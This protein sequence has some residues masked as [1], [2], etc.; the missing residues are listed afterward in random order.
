M[1]TTIFLS[2]L[3]FLSLHVYGQ[4]ENNLSQPGLQIYKLKTVN[5]TVTVNLP[6]K[7]Y[8][9]E[10]ISGT[11]LAEP[12]A[13][14]NVKKNKSNRLA[15]LA[16]TLSIFGNRF[17]PDNQKLNFSLPEDPFD[18]GPLIKLENEEGMIGS[19][20]FIVQEGERPV[21]VS[22]DPVFPAFLRSGEYQNIPGKFD[23]VLSNTR[24]MLNDLEIPVASESPG[25]IVTLVP[26]NISGNQKLTLTEGSKTYSAPI[27]VVNLNMTAEAST[28]QKGEKST[29]HIVVNGLNGIETPV[30]VNVDN[31]TPMS[32][33]MKGGNQQEWVIHPSEIDNTGTVS[34]D[35]EIV[36]VA[37]GGFT[38]SAR[39]SVPPVL[40]N[41]DGQTTDQLF[42]E[43]DKQ[44][45]DNK[46]EDD[47]LCGKIWKSDWKDTGKD[48]M[49]LDENS[50]TSSTYRDRC[51]NCSKNVNYN[52]VKTPLCKFS[53]FERQ[54]LVC[55]GKK[56]HSGSCHGSVT[57]EQKKEKDPGAA[58]K[59]Y[60]ETR[61]CQK[62]GRTETR[63]VPG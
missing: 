35:V 23:G 41:A 37:S 15:L 54:V 21:P 8:P 57:T 14:G 1:R 4:V 29:V 58:P 24:L 6:D 51:N 30:T 33:G 45:G 22:G 18:F 52:S 60:K 25:E 36:A 42:K 2:V 5:G 55:S 44:E 34:K 56:G 39:I 11:V 43:A 27:N 62:C 19:A 13:S 3:L 49:E 20:G 10:T 32:I 12:T 31:L 61:T 63:W 53:I 40:F 59:Q 46:G 38:V 47:G 26:E 48:V 50:S 7:I 9:G 16:T 17:K 28:L